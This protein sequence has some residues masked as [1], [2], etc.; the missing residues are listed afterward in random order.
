MHLDD[1]GRRQCRHRAEQ[2]R[3]RPIDLAVHTPFVRTVESLDLVLDGR[4]VPRVCIAEL[5]D[6]RLGVFEGR[7]VREY[8]DWRH[9]RPSSDRPADGESRIDALARYLAGAEILRDLEGATVL[10]VL[11]DVP[12]RFIANAAHGDDPIDGPIQHVGN[13]EMTEL[14]RGQLTAAVAAMRAR[15]TAAGLRT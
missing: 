15:L 9:G 4:K 6:V 3:S 14:D 12:I 7:P 11:H 8:R 1:V 13:M 5:G 2:L 10:A